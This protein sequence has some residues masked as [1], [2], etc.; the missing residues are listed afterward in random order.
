MRSLPS[1]FLIIF[2]AIFLSHGQEKLLF[3]QTDWGNQISIDEFCERAKSSGYDG[4]ETWFP[5]DVKK[6]EELK[7]ALKKHDLLVIF[8]HGTNKGLPFKQGLKKFKEELNTILEWKTI[9]VNCHTASDFYSKKQNSDIINAANRLSVEHNVP[10]YHETHRGRFSYSLPETNL[11]LSSI[12]ELKLTLDISHWMVVHESL[13]EG[14]DHLLKTVKNRS[15]HIHASVGHAEGPQVNDPKA[16]EW[17]RAMERHLEI[18]EEV[19]KKGWEKHQGV[20]T[21][22]TEFGPADYMPT[23][24]YTKAPLSDQWRANV[25]IMESL[26]ERLK[27][28][29]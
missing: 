6:Q 17:E 15:N 27:L 22:T 11:Y 29:K 2:G 14:K 7:S 10:V 21:V 1:L 23:L 18:W 9:L 28:N 20:F 4:I 19:I 16:P 24:P 12:P 5:W 13:L 3:F 8:L 25:F 26:K